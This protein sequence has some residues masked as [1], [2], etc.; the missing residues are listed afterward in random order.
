ML[1]TLIRL[2]GDFDRAEEA[3]AD[4]L[5]AAAEAWARDGVPDKPG[6]WLTTVAKRKALDRIRRDAARARREAEA[7]RLLREDDDEMP[8]DTGDDRLRLLFT[9][10]HPALG[11][12]AQIALTL[13][14]ICGLTTIEIA[15]LFLVPEPTIGQRISRAKAKIRDARIPYRVP[16]PHELPD[17][18][19]AVLA[20]IYAMFTA[21]HHSPTG[22]AADRMSL[23]TEAIRVTR[24][25]IELMP[26]EGECQGLL[27]L[28]LA[29]HA[30]LT[31]RFTPDGDVVL[32]ADQDRS[33]W[34]HAAIAEAAALIEAILRR[35]RVG[36][37]QIQGAISCL[38][39]LAPTWEA[40]DW[41]QIAV[42]YRLLEERTPTP[43]VRVNRAVAEAE[44]NGPQSGLALLDTIAEGPDGALAQRWHLYWSTRGEFLHRLDATAAA[45]E[46]FRRALDCA[47]N[48]A[49]RRFLE[50]RLAHIS[51]VGA[52][53]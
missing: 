5:A 9:C 35:G 33:R 49:D 6:A 29:S 26:D 48:D 11:R 21:G 37:Y 44:A 27:A 18:L 3:V 19:A 41:P 24:L 31:A 34:D 46:A 53:V 43:V 23:A 10:C 50:R 15:R 4:A 13:R 47:P 51:A 20:T 42:L 38:H 17:R 39:G 45:T 1:A 32:L 36:Q 40:T 14:T 12:D 22:E 52:P 2:T 25:L 16:E 30:R 7:G 8:G 28:M